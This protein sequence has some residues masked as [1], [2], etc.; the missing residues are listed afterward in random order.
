[1]ADA[2]AT[3]T[4]DGYIL[5]TFTQDDGKQPQYELSSDLAEKVK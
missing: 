5:L 1:M 3:P 4:L 2:T